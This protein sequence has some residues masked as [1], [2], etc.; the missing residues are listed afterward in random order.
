[1][2]EQEVN[3]PEGN[4]VSLTFSTVR[5]IYRTGISLRSRERFLYI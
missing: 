3:G 1:M 2:E 4:N 5:P